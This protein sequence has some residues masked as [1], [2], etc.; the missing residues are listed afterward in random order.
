MPGCTP[1]AEFYVYNTH[2]ALGLLIY[3]AS[4]DDI[5]D[6]TADTAITIEGKTLAV[7]VG[8]DNATWGAIYTANT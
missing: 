6:G 2:A 3:P 1:A 8:L 4:G 5:N 7:F